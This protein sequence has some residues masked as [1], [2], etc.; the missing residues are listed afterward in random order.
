MNFGSTDCAQPMIYAL[1]KK[2]EV[3]V[4]IVYTSSETSVGKI[5]PSEALKKYRK[6]MNRPQAKL[7]VMAMKVNNFS[8]ADPKDRGM[9]DIAGF[10]S[11]VPDIIC[12]F[13]KGKVL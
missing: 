4:F 9:L 10:D 3:D 12:E 13:V 11:S 7:I 1:E 5:H 2:I 6:K 8:I